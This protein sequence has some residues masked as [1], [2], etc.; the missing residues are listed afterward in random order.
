MKIR[1]LIFIFSFSIIKLFATA[2]APDKII[3]ENKEYDLLNNPLENYFVE[4]PDLDPIYG[5]KIKMF[6]KYKTEIIP[7][8]FST[9]NYRG[10]IA[11]FKIENQLLKLVDIK[12]QNIES[13][14]REYISVYKELFGDKNIIINYSGI[15]VVPIGKFLDS[16]NFGYSY[17]YSEYKLI[18]I[19]NDKIQKSKNLKKDEY[20]KFKFSQ[21]EEYKKTD[22]F[23]NSV[24]EYFDNW[25]NDKKMELSIENTKH[26]SKKEIQ[27]LKREYANPPKNELVENFIFLTK[28]IDFV[29][30]DY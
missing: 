4:N 14:K 13:E 16:A 19:K 22:D 28:N 21:F 18:T 15:L 11:T 7:I 1:L 2:Q 3:I 12:V 29:I 24:R 30:V 26:L 9:G 25:R 27:E 5:G 6:N 8:P 23:K 20:L 10:Y 17:L